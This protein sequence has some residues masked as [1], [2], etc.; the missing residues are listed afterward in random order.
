[1]AIVK[2]PLARE[3]L[4]HLPYSSGFISFI[5]VCEVFGVFGLVLPMWLGILPGSHRLRPLV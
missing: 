4:D 3:Q 1:M 2:P 5:G